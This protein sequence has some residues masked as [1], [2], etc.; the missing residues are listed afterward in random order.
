M[1]PSGFPKPLISDPLELMGR[2]GGGVGV[3]YAWEG[4]VET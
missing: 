4:W 1:C 3:R 2:E